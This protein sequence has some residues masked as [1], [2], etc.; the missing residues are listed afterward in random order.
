MTVEV[1]VGNVTYRQS[2]EEF[3]ERNWSSIGWYLE[4]VV[5]GS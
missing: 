5:W 3:I 2:F 1:V 4:V